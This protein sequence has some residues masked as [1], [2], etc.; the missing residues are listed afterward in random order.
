M[1]STDLTVRAVS[2]KQRSGNNTARVTASRSRSA[3][4]ERSRAFS[5]LTLADDCQLNDEDPSSANSSASEENQVEQDLLQTSLFISYSPDAAFHEM[6]LIMETV[7]QLK[8]SK[9]TNIWF[10]AD[11]SIFDTAAWYS[12]RI[13]VAEST[14]AVIMFLSA[15]YITSGISVAERKLFVE[16]LKDR[17]HDLKLYLV[18]VDPVDPS[19]DLKMVATKTVDLTCGTDPSKSLYDCVSLI[20]SRFG[21][22]LRKHSQFI[23]DSHGQDTR[24]ERMATNDS[25]CSQKKLRDWSADD[26]QSWLVKIGLKEFY[27][28]NL[29]EQAVDGVLLKSMTDGDLTRIAGIESNFVRRKVQQEVSAICVREE[30]QAVYW[31]RKLLKQHPKPNCIFIVY[32]LADASLAQT[33]AQDLIKK[34]FKVTPFLFVSIILFYCF[35]SIIS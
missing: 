19:F 15:S 12:E 32:E 23:F 9:V 21:P 33:L 27:R 17:S 28:T 5:S 30:S 26:V 18:I 35:Y 29:A 6:K 7:R 1:I 11:K 14:Q 25:P 24:S 10:D 34:Q 3:L 13:R 22:A 20:F 4:P 2:A 16:R 8:E 31:H